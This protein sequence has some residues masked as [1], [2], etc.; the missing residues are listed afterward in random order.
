MGFALLFKLYILAVVGRSEN[1]DKDLCI[2]GLPSTFPGVNTLH[3]LPHSLG[4]VSYTHGPPKPHTKFGGVW[5][6][7]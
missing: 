1:Y 5:A 4:L 7:I 3:Q 6:L 2:D